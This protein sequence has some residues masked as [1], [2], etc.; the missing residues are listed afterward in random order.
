MSLTLAELQT[1]LISYS[2]AEDKILRGQEYSIGDVS[3]TR[4]DLRWIQAERKELESRIARLQAGRSGPR[5]RRALP[6]D[7]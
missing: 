6:R 3:V 2:A 5:V 7:L 4:A 1:K